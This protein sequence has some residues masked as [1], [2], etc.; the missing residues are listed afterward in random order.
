MP[1]DDGSSTPDGF[2]AREGAEGAGIA[3]QGF[4]GAPAADGLVR[5]YIQGESGYYTE[6]AE[7]SVL[8]VLEHPTEPAPFLGARAVT[9]TVR[10][11][12]VL[13]FVW[14]TRIDR[15]EDDFDVD[16]TFGTE[17]EAPGPYDDDHEITAVMFT[18]RGWTCPASSCKRT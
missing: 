18:C 7:D 17:P 16:V 1:E 11:D 13:R 15:P 14:T 2:A 9:L 3:V 6:I 4:L 5:L 10:S 12:A 8:A